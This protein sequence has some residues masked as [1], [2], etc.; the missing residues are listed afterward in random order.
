MRGTAL[1]PGRCLPGPSRRAK[2]DDLYGKCR[3]RRASGQAFDP[4]DH[5]LTA[6]DCH[7]GCW[8]A[9]EKIG[10]H[11]GNFSCAAC[12]PVVAADVLAVPAIHPRVAVTHSPGAPI[13][14]TQRSPLRQ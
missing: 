3:K 14:P 8:D 1:I 5:T 7:I 13:V 9:P 6:L 4:T 11:H 2:R 12:P 10:V